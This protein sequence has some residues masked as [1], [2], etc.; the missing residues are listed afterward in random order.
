MINFNTCA[1]TVTY[2]FEGDAVRNLFLLVCQIHRIQSFQYQ[3]SV[4]HCF[5]WVAIESFGS[6]S[7]VGVQ[8]VK[9]AVGI[10]NQLSGCGG[11]V[12]YSPNGKQCYALSP[13][14]HTDIGNSKMRLYGII[15]HVNSRHG[16][17]ERN[18]QPHISP[19]AVFPQVNRLPVGTG[20]G[21][22]GK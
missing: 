5:A 16:T 22:W 4:I 3:E 6:S 9:R 7:C 12:A 8:P 18:I 21:Q 15:H 13:V 20:H 1:V 2:P 17:G 19:H 14:A 10:C 11:N